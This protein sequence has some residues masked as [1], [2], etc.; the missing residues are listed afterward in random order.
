VLT[1]L[2]APLTSCA[3]ATPPG[4]DNF[5]GQEADRALASMIRSC[6]QPRSLSALLACTGARAT[7]AR[8]KVAAHLDGLLDG[9]AC[10]CGQGDAGG[11][12]PCESSSRPADSRL[13]S[14]AAPPVLASSKPQRHP[15]P[16]GP[17][18]CA[19]PVPRATLAAHW[20]LLD[21]LF[22]ASAAFLEEGSLDTRTHGKRL[23]FEIR[24]SVPGRGDWERLL[25]GLR[26]EALQ[27]K[28]LEVLDA[29]GGPPPPP[30]TR[31][32]MGECRGALGDCLPGVCV[33]P[34]P[35]VARGVEPQRAAVVT[36]S[37]VTFCCWMLCA[38]FGPHAQGCYLSALLSV[39]IDD[40]GIWLNFLI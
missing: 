31:G 27:R 26:P 28:V 11:D 40:T 6:S 14:P 34:L 17:P 5:L 23:L 35:P 24:A 21:R 3:P 12:L 36:R 2:C 29:P 30:A 7:A 8:T 16:T 37:G 39:H 9:G 33:G 4:R 19:V 25:A 18:P 22:K 20:A 10:R 13:E 32:R 1:P 15:P 38:L